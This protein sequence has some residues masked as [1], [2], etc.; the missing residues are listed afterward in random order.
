MST[1]KLPTK[2]NG[3]LDPMKASNATTAARKAE[4]LIREGMTSTD[5]YFSSMVTLAI[6]YAAHAVKAHE[7]RETGEA[8]FDDLLNFFSDPSYQQKVLRLHRD[9]ASGTWCIPAPLDD[10][11][12][13]FFEHA[14]YGSWDEHTRRQTAISATNSLIEATR[15]NR[16]RQPKAGRIMPAEQRTSGYFLPYDKDPMSDSSPTQAAESTAR[17]VMDGRFTEEKYFPEI[18]TPIIRNA[19]A[20]VKSYEECYRARRATIDLLEL[21]FAN[22]EYRSIVLVTLAG[23]G[24]IALRPPG[25]QLASHNPR[26]DEATTRFFAESFF[27]FYRPDLQLYYLWCCKSAVASAMYEESEAAASS[28]PPRRETMKED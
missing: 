24:Q 22:P 7:D 19:A 23:C 18:I 15:Y 14:Y 9:Q 13:R 25:E 8:C 10:E 1:E 3:L 27:G 2:H 16:P 21:F 12:R 28:R 4:E 17:F 26:L 20:A 5:D 6:H 11:V